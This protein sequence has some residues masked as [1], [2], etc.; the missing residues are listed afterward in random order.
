MIPYGVFIEKDV[1]TVVTDQQIIAFRRISEQNC[2]ESCLL[3]KDVATGQYLC[4]GICRSYPLHTE[5]SSR[6]HRWKYAFA[7]QRKVYAND[8][9]LARCIGQPAL[10]ITTIESGVKLEYWDDKVYNL[11]QDECFTM[12]DLHPHPPVICE[13]NVGECLRCWHMGC[14]EETI[15]ANQDRFTEVTINTAKHMYIFQMVPSSFYCRAA[16]YATCD[17]GVVYSQN[18]RQRKSA[19]PETYMAEDNTI[20]LQPITVT[21]SDFETFACSLIRPE[22]IAIKYLNDLERQILGYRFGVMG[23]EKLSQRKAAALLGISPSSVARIAMRAEKTLFSHMPDTK[24]KGIF[25]IVESFT[26]NQITLYGCQGDV[27]QWNKPERS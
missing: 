8:E 9:A 11:V 16:R 5:P 15:E 7:G 26:D 12:E 13:D 23:Y 4:A 2:L 27:Y 19:T 17:R 24:G 3:R 6:P 10:S 1:E 18:F 21:E 14:M 25:W 22:V 20:A